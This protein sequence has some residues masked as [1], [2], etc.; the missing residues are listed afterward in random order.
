MESLTDTASSIGKGFSKSFNRHTNSATSLAREVKDCF[1]LEEMLK[2]ISRLGKDEQR[3][4][5][6]IHKPIDWSQQS[7]NSFD[8]SK[9]CKEYLLTPNSR[10]IQRTLSETSCVLVTPPQR[11][12]L[13]KSLVECDGKLWSEATRTRAVSDTNLH[14]RRLMPKQSTLNYSDGSYVD[15]KGNVRTKSTLEVR[16]SY[17]SQ[18]PKSINF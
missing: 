11:R 10:H 5:K 4:Q 8:H 12:K 15:G 13:E 3:N 6:V 1:D 2:S 17:Q 14:T 18:R 16:E 7:S 9:C